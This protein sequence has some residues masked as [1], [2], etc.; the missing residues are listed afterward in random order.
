M[1]KPDPRRKSAVVLFQDPDTCK[2]ITPTLFA[3]LPERDYMS[4]DTGLLIPEHRLQGR[5]V[6]HGKVWLVFTSDLDPVMALY[7]YELKES[8]QPDIVRDSD[9]ELERL[10]RVVEAIRVR[11]GRFE[12]LPLRLRVTGRTFHLPIYTHK[13][14]E[15]RYP[16]MQ[17]TPE[18]LVGVAKKSAIEH[19]LESEG[20]STDIT[21]GEVVGIM[22]SVI[23]A[24]EK[25]VTAWTSTRWTLSRSGQLFLH[26]ED[27]ELLASKVLNT[28]RRDKP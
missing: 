12:E 24:S 9:N 7:K 2:T 11:D 27:D 13:C 25:R 5:V 4:H 15:V 22:E 8:D 16:Y 19:W 10:A 20:F 14:W 21:E 18:G 26:P 6:W 3:Q 28:I 23:T 1:M 17:L